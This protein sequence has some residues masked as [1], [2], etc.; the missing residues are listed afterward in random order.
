MWCVVWGGL[1]SRSVAQHN[2]DGSVRA[3]VSLTATA[4]AT[5][6]TCVTY[7]TIHS[8]F[9]QHLYTTVYQPVCS[10]PLINNTPHAKTA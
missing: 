5:V 9:A 7:A 10:V 2:T 6:V 1:L 4:V 8:C 3:S